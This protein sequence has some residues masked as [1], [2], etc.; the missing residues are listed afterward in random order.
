[1]WDVENGIHVALKILKASEEHRVV[2]D[3][4]IDVYEVLNC[5]LQAEDAPVEAEFVMRMYEY[6][7]H[8]GRTW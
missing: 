3:Y 6:F 4:E 7:E 8:T 2:S 5:T 1:M